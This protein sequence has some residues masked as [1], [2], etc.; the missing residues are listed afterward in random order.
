MLSDVIGVYFRH[1]KAPGSDFVERGDYRLV[2]GGD[3][4][5]MGPMEW[6]RIKKAGLTIEMSILLRTRNEDDATCPGCRTRFEG[7][8]IDGWA[9]W[10]VSKKHSPY[11]YL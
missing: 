6:P 8:A 7:R 11:L 2:R 10:Q 1:Q 3:K 4:T 5:V 9:Q